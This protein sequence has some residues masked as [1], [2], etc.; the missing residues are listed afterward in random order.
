MGAVLLKLDVLFSFYFISVIQN[1]MNKN[2]EDKIIS[3]FYGKS[4]TLVIRTQSE[5]DANG[6]VTKSVATK[7]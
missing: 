3:T 1:I 6:S 4:I 7:R 2:F 5:L